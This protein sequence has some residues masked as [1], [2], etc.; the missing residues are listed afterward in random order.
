[1]HDLHDA[2]PNSKVV[3]HV[4]ERIGRASADIDRRLQGDCRL[5]SE[6]RFAKSSR[7]LRRTP[8]SGEDLIQT[9]FHIASR[10]NSQSA[11]KRLEETP[12]KSAPSSC[13]AYLAREPRLHLRITNLITMSIC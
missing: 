7:R 10:K 8:R 13:F 2:R 9:H 3:G 12:K 11:A 4:E 5:P 1:M 6:F